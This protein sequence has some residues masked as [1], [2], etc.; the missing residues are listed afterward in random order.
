MD[1]LPLFF[2]SLAVSLLLFANCLSPMAILS[3]L[4]LHE[5]LLFRDILPPSHLGFPG[6]PLGTLHEPAMAWST[7]NPSSN[8]A[9][10]PS[11]MNQMSSHGAF[12]RY[13]QKSYL[14]IK[15]KKH[16]DNKPRIIFE[17]AKHKLTKKKLP[18]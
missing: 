9:V 1:S 12:F 4:F 10:Y 16:N 3:L 2:H 11:Y 14:L 7:H 13:K 15:K 5:P 6:D 8:P 17:Q 18:Q